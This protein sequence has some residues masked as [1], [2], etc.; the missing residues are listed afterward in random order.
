MWLLFESFWLGGKTLWDSIGGTK[1]RPWAIGKRLGDL[2]RA[3]F[4]HGRVKKSATQLFWDLGASWPKGK[5]GHQTCTENRTEKK[6]NFSRNR[7]TVEFSCLFHH[8]GGLSGI[9]KKLLD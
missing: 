2:S 8:N 4:T 3:G 1:S 6:K 9:K 7:N 5:E